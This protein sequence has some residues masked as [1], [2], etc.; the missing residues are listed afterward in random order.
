MSDVIA[1][2]VRVKP[3]T[4]RVLGVLKERYGLRDK[5]EALDRFAEMFGNEFVEREAKEEYVKK[6]LAIHHEHIKKHPRRVMSDEELDA[7]CGL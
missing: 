5:G 2:N 6:I 1:M 7:L 4:S 3:Y